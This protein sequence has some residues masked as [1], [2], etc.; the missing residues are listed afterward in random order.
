MKLDINI[1]D[2]KTPKNPFNNTYWSLFNISLY[3]YK[4]IKFT[5]E[6]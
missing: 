4:R 5:V 1:Q 6:I 3:V 2:N